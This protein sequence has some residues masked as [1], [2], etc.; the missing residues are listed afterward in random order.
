MKNQEGLTLKTYEEKY[1]KVCLGLEDV[2]FD[3]SE[4]ESSSE[5]E[6]SES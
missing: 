4:E 6:D 5:E 1:G 3:L 2:E